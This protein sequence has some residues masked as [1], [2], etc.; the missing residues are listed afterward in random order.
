LFQ[1]LGFTPLAERRETQ[2]ISPLVIMF[3]AR[4]RDGKVMLLDSEIIA[5]A[6]KTNQVIVPVGVLG[7]SRSANHP[8]ISSWQTTMPIMA[9]AL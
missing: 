6:W 7:S 2:L 4:G 1:R 3:C 9:M 8:R 5:P